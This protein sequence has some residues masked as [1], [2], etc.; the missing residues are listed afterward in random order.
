MAP[1]FS[2]NAILTGSVDNFCL[3]CETHLES[4]RDILAHITKP[5][6]TKTLA[7]TCFVEQYKTDM[8]RKV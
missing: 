3:V 2:K 6:H 5:V 8:I 7:A 4:D 1:S